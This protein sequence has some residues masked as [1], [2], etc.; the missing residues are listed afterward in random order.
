MSEHSSASVYTRHSY[1]F[2]QNN[3]AATKSEPFALIVLNTPLCPSDR[4]FRALWANASLRVAADG[5]AEHLLRFADA[6]TS[7]GEPGVAPFVPDAVVG[8]MDSASAVTL[9]HMRAAGADVVHVPEQD[10][11]DLDKSIFYV[12]HTRA[13]GQLPPLSAAEGRHLN[14]PLLQSPVTTVVC[15]G[16]F[17]GRFDQQMSCLNALFVHNNLPSV[18][19]ASASR[20]SSADV[21]APLPPPL[22]QCRKPRLVLVGDDNVSELLA[23]GAHTIVQ[24]TLTLLQTAPADASVAA[25]SAVSAATAA[26]DVPVG[27]YVGFFPLNCCAPPAQVVTAGFQWDLGSPEASAAL[28]RAASAA[29]AATVAAAEGASATEAAGAGCGSAAAAAFAAALPVAATAAAAAVAADIPAAVDAS[30]VAAAAIA[31]FCTAEGC[32]M[33]LGGLVSTSNRLMPRP[34][35]LPV[36]EGAATAAAAAAVE[37][38]AVVATAQPLVWTAAFGHAYRES[39]RRNR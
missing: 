10:S 21:S 4:M 30:A 36:L 31:R 9:A 18:Y 16:S 5:G 33:Q 24:P 29:E 17:G 37:A 20:S 28:M 38:V 19:T 3:Y 32:G 15:F 6:C 11:T 25:T 2:L 1:S 27:F 14:A 8:D 23:A 7:A 34:L 13:L 22:L 12:M 35:A 26:P 39:S